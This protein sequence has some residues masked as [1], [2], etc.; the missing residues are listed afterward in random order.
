MPVCPLCLINSYL[1]KKT[2]MQV[3][4]LMTCF[5]PGGANHLCLSVPIMHFLMNCLHSCIQSSKR[6]NHPRITAQ[7]LLYLMFNKYVLNEHFGVSVVELGGDRHQRVSGSW[8][9]VLHNTSSCWSGHS[10]PCRVLEW[11]PATPPPVWL[12]L[13]YNLGRNRWWFKYLSPFV[14]DMGWVPSP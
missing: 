1:S 9:G 12:L 13:I 11:V 6:S 10:I 7:N 4:S 3:L 2:Q 14:G 5:F 8:R